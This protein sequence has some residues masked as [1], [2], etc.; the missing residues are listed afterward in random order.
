MNGQIAV[1]LSMMGSNAYDGQWTEVQSFEELFGYRYWKVPFSRPLL[2]EL[3]SLS[4]LWREASSPP[5]R[6]KP[7]R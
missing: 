5:L 4:R 2:L 7:R 1:R 6:G 3:G